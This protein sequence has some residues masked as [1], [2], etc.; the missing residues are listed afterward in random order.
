M[1]RYLL[2]LWVTILSLSTTQAQLLSQEEIYSRE[3]IY[4]VNF[5]TNGGLIGGVM[6][7]F[8]ALRNSVKMRQY[9]TFGLEIVNVK[10]N[11][12]TRLNSFT[13]NT[14]IFNKKNCCLQETFIDSCLIAV[15][16]VCLAVARGI[17]TA[18]N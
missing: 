16:C 5:N 6:F 13:G 12:E 1:R 7:K 15:V 8:S 4:G 18:A 11:K 10:H 2:I 3:F 9:S 17:M 14:Y